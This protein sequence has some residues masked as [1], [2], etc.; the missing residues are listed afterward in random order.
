MMKGLR[1]WRHLAL[2]AALVMAGVL[3]PLSANWS[4]KAQIAGGMIAI[5]INIAVLLVIFER[6]W[7]RSWLNY[8]EAGGDA[9]RDFTVRAEEM[10]NH[11]ERF[12][13]ARSQTATSRS[14]QK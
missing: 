7:E 6:R 2:L 3:E 4:E 11:I 14:S 12:R 9:A 8:G 13:I 1:E 10:T 5:L